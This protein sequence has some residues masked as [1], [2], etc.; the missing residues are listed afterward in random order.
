[1]YQEN[2]DFSNTGLTQAGFTIFTQVIGWTNLRIVTLVYM[3]VDQSYPYNLN[4]FNNI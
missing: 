2:F 1:M 3:A 4:T